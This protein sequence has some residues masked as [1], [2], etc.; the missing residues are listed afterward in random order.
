MKK[1]E[2]QIK[3]NEFRFKTNE[4]QSEKKNPPQKKKKID[5]ASLSPSPLP[6]LLLSL[7]FPPLTL[8]VEYCNAHTQR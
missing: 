1:I 3:I 2:L 5:T 4:V 8:S 7:P 6:T